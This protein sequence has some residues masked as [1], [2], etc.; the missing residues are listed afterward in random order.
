[1]SA[2]STKPGLGRGFD[3][4]I[5]THLVEE[6]FDPTA[7]TDKSI[8]R[9]QNIT[10]K[11][12]HRNPDQP[13][14]AFTAESIKELADSIKAHGIIQPLIVT[15]AKDG[16]T[17]IAGE[18]RWRAA[19][20]AKLKTV[21]VIVRSFSDQARLEVALV[22][23]LQR[24]DLN[25]LEVATALYKLNDQFNMSLGQIGKQVG[26]SSS[27]V[28]NT[29][30]LLGLGKKAKD[31]LAKGRISEGHARSILALPESLQEDLLS[32]IIK[33]G[34]SVRRAEQYVT[35]HKQGGRVKQT[36]KAGGSAH[37]TALTRKA[38]KALK[39][40]VRDRP[41]AKGSGR[42]IISYKD[43]ADRKRIIDTISK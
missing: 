22:E 23:N 14:K 38:E 5:P 19:K 30:R 13:R 41:M 24:E 43:S 32:H 6:E 21:P 8:S 29:I 26:K 12:I 34:W 17:I 39:T 36:T 7:K 35:A 16:Y 28:S 10:V 25:P 3:S 33:N 40:E 20:E 27:A 37:Q 31:A 42:L 2:K 9:T 1:M 18:R 4:L 11:D 15:E